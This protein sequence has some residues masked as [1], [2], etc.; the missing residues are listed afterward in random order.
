M[1]ESELPPLA[2]SFQDELNASI[3]SSVTNVISDLS[4]KIDDLLE[5]IKFLELTLDATS[6]APREANENVKALKAK[7]EQ[8]DQI[9]KQ[10]GQLISD[11][12]SYF[13]GYNP[14]LFHIPQNLNES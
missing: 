1:A 9:I 6:V 8:Q 2:E 13:K 4:K 14:K 7:I 10:Q 5:Y 12:K 11:A 3:T